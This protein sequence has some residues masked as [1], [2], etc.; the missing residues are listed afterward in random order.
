VSVPIH[1]I[2]AR[3]MVGRGEYDCIW[4][5]NT[6]PD[7]SPNATGSKDGI[8]RTSA[9]PPHPHRFNIYQVYQV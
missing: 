5:A 4:G 3:L 8:S 7:G 1:A 2:E 9:L 6:S